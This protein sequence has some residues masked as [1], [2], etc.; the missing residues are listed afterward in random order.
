[1]ELVMT[2]NHPQA[3]CVDLRAT[4]AGVFNFAWEES[5]AAERPEFRAIEAP[6]LTIIPGERGRIFPWG[7]TRL[8]AYSDHGPTVRALTAMPCATVHAGGPQEVIVLFEA[9]DIDAVAA[10]L[11]SSRY[12]RPQTDDEHAAWLQ[13]HRA[14][15][16]K[17]NKKATS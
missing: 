1:M 15:H 5:Y 3:Q 17:A 13:E 6:W 9:T 10:V 11:G 16:R 4:F 2:T 12:V 14:R 7:R 8:A